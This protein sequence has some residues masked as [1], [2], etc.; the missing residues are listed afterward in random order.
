MFWETLDKEVNGKIEIMSTI[1]MF[2]MLIFIFFL[3]WNL[4]ET[5]QDFVEQPIDSTDIKQTESNK[6]TQAT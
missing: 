1:T 5:Y 4:Q 6:K 3:I 2:F